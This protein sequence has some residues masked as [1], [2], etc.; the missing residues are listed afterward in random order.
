MKDLSI[1]PR[2]MSPRLGSA[3]NN[4]SVALSEVE[5][6]YAVNLAKCAEKALAV[7]ADQLSPVSW[8]SA[9]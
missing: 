2:R 3:I 4:L 6:Q 8:E 5:K 1:D 7:A 9:E